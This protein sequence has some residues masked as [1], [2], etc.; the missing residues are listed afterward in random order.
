MQ[1]HSTTEKPKFK[2]NNHHDLAE[3]D[4]TLSV[5]EPA[6]PLL[7]VLPIKRWIH[8]ELSNPGRFGSRPNIVTA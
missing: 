3:P 4:R 7:K 6:E 2:V 5:G 1:P 8:P